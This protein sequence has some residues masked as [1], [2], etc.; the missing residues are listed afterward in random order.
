MRFTTLDTADLHNL[1][2]Y[3]DL[4]PLMKV[5]PSGRAATADWLGF[6]LAGLGLAL[7][8][9]GVGAA[10]GAASIASAAAGGWAALALPTKLALG[11]AVG[12]AVLDLG[13]ATATAIDDIYTD[14]ID[15]TTSIAIG[16]TS[17]V[18]GAT[19]AIGG[20][21]SAVRALRTHL[22]IREA[23]S[24]QVTHPAKR[25]VISE[26]F[27]IISRVHRVPSGLTHHTKML[28]FVDEL[29]AHPNA[30]GDYTPGIHTLR[31]RNDA[32]VRTV[33]HEIGHYFD[34]VVFDDQTTKIV[35]DFANY[36]GPFS[37]WR[38]AT[39]ETV[40]YRAIA[41]YWAKN[42]DEDVFELLR[43]EELFADSY[44]QWVTHRASNGRDTWI[45]AAVAQDDLR[46][47]EETD[48][49]EVGRAMDDLFQPLRY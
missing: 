41:Q 8:L 3:A 9:I 46:A 32:Q 22:D 17:A 45:D 36:D 2:N 35:S 23:V 47:W 30:R 44:A 38:F 15:D 40:R 27:D 19:L 18:L 42:R 33:L 7:S 49:E 24:V 28:R 1:Y 6:V 29:P 48:F 10:L 14:I 13:A 4:N 12:I 26:A 31:L 25:R 5:D 11:A 43:V 20:V 16:A 34:T 39:R 21:R 37:K